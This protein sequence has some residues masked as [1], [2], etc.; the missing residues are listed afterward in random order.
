MSII[1]ISESD[2]TKF[3]CY[4][5]DDGSLYY[6]ETEYVDENKQGVIKWNDPRFNI[7]WPADNP[8]LQKR[9]R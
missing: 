1:D 8:V 7:E 2:K 5:F 9:D 4:K 6:G 3:K